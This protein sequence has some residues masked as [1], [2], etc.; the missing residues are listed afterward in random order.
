[1]INEWQKA[2]FWSRVDMNADGTSQQAGYRGASC[3]LWTGGVASGYGSATF[4][5]RGHRAHRLAYELLVGR[6]PDG[7]Q[8]DHLCRVQ[9]CVNPRHL[10]PVTSR[11]NTRRG[12]LAEAAKECAAARM[13][14][15]AGHPYSELNTYFADGKRQCRTCHRLF[16]RSK[17]PLQ[18]RV[19]H[20]PLREIVAREGKRADLICG[21]TVTRS[22]GRP[23]RRCRC[24][25]CDEVE[26]NHHHITQTEEEEV[27]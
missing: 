4:D 21:H 26:T 20:G 15:G 1:M 24:P 3:W 16:A 19:A 7:L 12:R 27:A 5:G 23:A 25:E 6:I 2:S 22:F 13:T 17:N 8:L 11:E 10:E 14:C 18:G 9:L